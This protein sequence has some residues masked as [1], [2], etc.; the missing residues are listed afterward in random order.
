MFEVLHNE[1]TCFGS[2]TSVVQHPQILVGTL[3][4]KTPHWPPIWNTY[5]VSKALPPSLPPQASP[6]FPS[7]LRKASQTINTQLGQLEMY[8]SLHSF[9]TVPSFLTLVCLISIPPPAAKEPRMLA[10][11][12]LVCLLSYSYTK[13]GLQSQ[14]VKQVDVNIEF[15]YQGQVRNSKFF[16]LKNT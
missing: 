2:L 5:R 3:L 7:H 6:S 4:P 14:W 8:S 1:S 10:P 15:T 16:P 13:Y 9:F 12:K 11:Y